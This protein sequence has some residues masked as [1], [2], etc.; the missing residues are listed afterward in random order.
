MNSRERVIKALNHEQPDRV[1]LDLGSTPVTGISAVALDRLRK[2]LKLEARKVKIYEPFQLLGEVEDDVL[3][4]TKADV[5]G[6]CSPYTSWGYKNE[7]WKD[8]TMPDQTEVLI[9]GGFTVTIDKNG[10]QFVYPGGD[11]SVP[12]SGKLPKDGYYFDNIT[13]QEEIDEDDLDGRRDFK[14][15]FKVFSE[16]DLKYYEKTANELYN[17]TEYAI[18]GNFIEGGLG[19]AA[20][21]PGPALK[22]TPGVRKLE[23]WLMYH[24]L[25]PE[26][27]CDVYDYQVEIVLQNLELYR[28]AVGDKIQ[29]ILV[30]GTDFG[31]Q[32]SEFI[33]PDLFRKIY[34]PRI[35]KINDWI[36]ENTSWKT[37]Y[38]SCGSIVN[39]LDDFVEAGID[40]INPVQCSAA[41]M[42]PRFLKEKYGNKLVF[43]GGGID[44]QKTLP[45]GTPEEVKQEALERLRIFSQGGGFIFNTIHNI[46][47]TTPIENI[48]ALFEAVHEFNE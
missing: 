39:L 35:K 4:A 9:G 8:W 5:V 22:K 27:V 2:A 31:T 33:S 30:S 40:I 25:Y 29:S 3:A 42:D 41:G 7:N 18:I 1:P 14:D 16:E 26:Y 19:D 34:K 44:T 13:R 32:R 36:H 38:H 47:S 17:N 15:Q 43:W 12:P 21:L 24:I 45:I 28:Q 20:A 11:T 6:L 48:L 46:Q 23:D 37:F 10:D